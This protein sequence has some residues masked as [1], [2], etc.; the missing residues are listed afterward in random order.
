VLDNAFTLIDGQRWRVFLSFF[1]TRHHSVYN[2]KSFRHRPDPMILGRSPKIPK[3]PTRLL[4]RDTQ[5]IVT[6]GK[7]SKIRRHSSAVS[8]SIKKTSN[9]AQARC[10]EQA[11]HK[12][13]NG[14]HDDSIRDALLLMGYGILPAQE[15][16]PVA[17]PGPAVRDLERKRIE[18][19]HG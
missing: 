17:E 12:H 10:D 5:G 18:A 16:V 8:R 19:P 3:M 15:L 1:W 9:R 11:V 7:C 13:C 6:H 2:W 4:Q 14:A